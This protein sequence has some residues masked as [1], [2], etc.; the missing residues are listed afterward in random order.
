PEILSDVQSAGQ[1]SVLPCRFTDEEVK[2]NTKGYSDTKHIPRS[3]VLQFGLKGDP[4]VH[5]DTITFLITPSKLDLRQLLAGAEVEHLSCGLQRYSTDGSHIRWP[6]KGER[7]Y[8]RWYTV[9]ISHS[10]N[11]FDI[12]GFIRQSTDQPPTGQHDYKS[13]AV[14]QDKEIL[15]TS[16]AM[17]M[18]TQTPV[19]KSLLKSQAKLHCQFYIDHKSPKVTLEWRKLRTKAPLFTYNS[20]SGQTQGSGVALKQLAAGGATYT[21][22]LTEVDSEGT[23]LCSVHV[24]PLLGSL[25]VALHKQAPPRV[26][27]NVSPTLTLS[28]DAVKTVVCSAE[29][30]YPL[31]VDILW[32]HR[33]STEVGPRVDS[34]QLT[35]HSKSPDHTYS[36]SAFFQLQPKLWDSGRKFTCSVHH[37]ALPAP[38]RKTFTLIVTEPFIHQWFLGFNMVI[39]AFVLILVLRKI[40]RVRRCR[41]LW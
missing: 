7:E 40:L 5:P 34:S 8:N 27:L 36:L 17:V 33:G 35:S 19:V 14:I 37:P 41:F 2:P 20:P 15:T 29:G 23:Y 1:I 26:S 32:S 9:N 11:L 28:E 18:Q 31:D 24:H 38:I 13:W 3:A 39:L 4:P 12:M 22:Q 10:K 6:V 16:V 25:K 30:Y 21:T